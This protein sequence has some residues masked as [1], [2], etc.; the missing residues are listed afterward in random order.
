VYAC[1]PHI[2]RKRVDERLAIENVSVRLKNRAS[3]GGLGQL[4][5]LPG[6]FRKERF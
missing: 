3:W 5:V 1:T 6:A 4:P 2:A